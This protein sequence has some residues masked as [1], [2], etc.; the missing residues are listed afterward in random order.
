MET[1]E[2]E[3]KG[4]SEFEERI[5]FLEAKLMS[6]NLLEERM[7]YLEQTLKEIQQDL[8]LLRIELE[9]VKRSQYR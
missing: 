3:E 9:K 4:F 6:L 7:N 5:R 1:L 2:N 8:E